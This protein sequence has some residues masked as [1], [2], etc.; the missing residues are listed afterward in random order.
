MGRGK[1]IS[2]ADVAVILDLQRDTDLSVSALSARI[3]RSKRAVTSIAARQNSSIRRRSIGRPSKVTPQS[4]RVIIRIVTK[5]V[6]SALAVA[7]QYQ[8]PVGLRHAQQLLQEA[9]HFQWSKL[10]RAPR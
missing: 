5:G 2:E 6:T 8:S 7:A 10:C 4:R 3:K 1:A 9:T